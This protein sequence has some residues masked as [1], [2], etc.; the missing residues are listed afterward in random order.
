MNAF[1]QP[2]SMQHVHGLWMIME[3]P[4]IQGI[5]KHGLLA[6]KRPS[7]ALQNVTFCRLKDRVLQGA[8]F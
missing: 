4:V 6:C 8:C 5:A 7:N 1:L 3:T 2:D